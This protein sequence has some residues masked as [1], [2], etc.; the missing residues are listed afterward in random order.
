MHSSSNALLLLVL[1][2]AT[3][4][5]S[6]TVVPRRRAPHRGRAAGLAGRLLAVQP[7]PHAAALPLL[8][9][10]RLRPPAVVLCRLLAVG[11]RPS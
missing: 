5:T 11:A 4:S 1:A 10:G 2:A 7:R 6:T 3:S 9:R 8:V